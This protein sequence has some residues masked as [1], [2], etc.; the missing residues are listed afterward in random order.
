MLLNNDEKDDKIGQTRVRRHESVHNTIESIIQ[1]HQLRVTVDDISMQTVVKDDDRLN[2]RDEPVVV[3]NNLSVNVSTMDND[4]LSSDIDSILVLKMEPY[5]IANVVNKNPFDKVGLVSQEKVFVDAL[6]NMQMVVGDKL[7]VN[8]GV[9]NC[10]ISSLSVDIVDVATHKSDND[11]R[12]I[13]KEK[14]STDSTFDI[15]IRLSANA[16]TMLDEKPTNA[17]PAK[18][19]ESLAGVGL[20]IILVDSKHTIVGQPSNEPKILSNGAFND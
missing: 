11:A 8:V 4:K 9:N 20:S 7:K 19:G 3:V 14:S 13:A 10:A 18:D 2:G 16:R 17:V 12:L 5:A 6:P 1:D 15:D